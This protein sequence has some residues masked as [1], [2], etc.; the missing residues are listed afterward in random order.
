VPA[1]SIA[2]PLTTAGGGVLRLGRFS[3]G[4]WIILV[5]GQSDSVKNGSLCKSATDCSMDEGKEKKKEKREKELE[6]SSD[7]W[8]AYKQVH[9]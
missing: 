9:P 6:C 5:T 7:G 3:V 4:T 8:D 1:A 2:S